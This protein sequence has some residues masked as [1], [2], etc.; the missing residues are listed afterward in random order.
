MELKKQDENVKGTKTAI[1]S[2]K[3]PTVL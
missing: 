3:I 1:K 2:S